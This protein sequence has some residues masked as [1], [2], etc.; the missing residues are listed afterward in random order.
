MNFQRFA[1][2]ACLFVFGLAPLGCELA[3]SVGDGNAHQNTNDNTADDG[4]G[5]S[6]EDPGDGSD[7]NV[8]DNSVDDDSDAYARFQ[9]PDSDFSTTNVRDVEEEIVRFVVATN[10]VE[11]A[12]DGRQF[13]AGSWTVSGN[14]L[15]RGGP[16][17]VLF[18]TKEGQRRAYFT[19]TSTSTICNLSIIGDSFFISPTDTPVPQE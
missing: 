13:S 15:G 4:N 2:F 1:T 8:N 6:N 10:A 5:N 18:G 16:F 7:A 12:A 3:D 17:Q 9:D 14:F 11:W 19:E